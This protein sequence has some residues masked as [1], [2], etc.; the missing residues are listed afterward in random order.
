VAAP[1]GPAFGARAVGDRLRRCLARARSLS[2]SPAFSLYL[3]EHGRARCR[4]SEHRG[5]PPGTVIVICN[6]VA[7]ASAPWRLARVRTV[8]ACRGFSLYLPEQ[9][10]GRWRPIE[11]SGCPCAI[12]TVTRQ[13]AANAVAPPAAIGRP[14]SA[15][16][17]RTLFVAGPARRP[18]VWSGPNSPSSSASR[19]IGPSGWVR[20]A[21]AATLSSGPYTP[22][23]EFVNARLGPEVPYLS[24]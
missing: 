15:N 22:A 5:R 13:L 9:G 21:P 19:F 20:A 17:T 7:R 6:L 16:T 3:C 2:V 14:V 11:H 24:L 10:R 12:R 8:S 18:I 4:S 23:G 1:V